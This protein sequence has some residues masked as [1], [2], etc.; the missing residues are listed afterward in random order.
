M[1]LSQTEV[2]CHTQACK[3]SLVKVPAIWRQPA[4]SAESEGTLLERRPPAELLEVPRQVRLVCRLRGIP[5]GFEL[6]LEGFAQ[7]VE[8]RQ[9]VRGQSGRDGP[10]EGAQR[11]RAALPLSDRGELSAG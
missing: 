8:R 10:L 9:V 3:M 1:R 4:P 5:A 6:C 2:L 7:L 11:I